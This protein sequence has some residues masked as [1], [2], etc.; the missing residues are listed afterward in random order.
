[1]TRVGIVGATGY[2]AFELI[3]ILLRHPQAEL[4]CV[5]SRENIGQPV[6]RVHPQFLGQLDLQFE[7]FSAG[8]MASKSDFVFTCLPHGASASSVMELRKQGLKVV[9]F[10]ADYRLASRDVYEDWY[11][12]E[13]P[14][15]EML[16]S[17]PYGLPEFFRDEIAA[18]DLVANP[19]CFPTSAI[20]GLA[21]LLK[22]GLISPS[23]L[24]IDSKTGVSGA[25]RKPN[26]AF[27]F[28]ECN[29]SVLAYKV[30]SHRHQPEIDDL[31]G[32]CSTA[33]TACLFT[34]HLIPMDRG[35]LSTLYAEKTDSVADNTLM[36]CLKDFYHSSRFV[37]VVNELPS[38]KAVSGTNFCDLTVRV[39]GNRVIV[40]SCL[41]NL[42]KGAS[43]AAVQ[44]FNLMNGYDEACALL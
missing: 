41:D 44:N 19:G 37:R 39:S 28:P 36:D 30:A 3:K 21:P 15:P 6:S 9:D 29:E 24:I 34:P 42:I 18:A 4:T 11:G 16:G 7:E 14:D 13:H 43:G 8:A 17:V 25:G 1:M 22:N 40:I 10:S 35:I 5:T 27:H 31:L 26:L 38:T 23:G 32:R 2:T 33:E 20:L 12:I